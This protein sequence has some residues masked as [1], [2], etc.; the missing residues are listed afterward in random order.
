MG[1]LNSV[2]KDDA[3]ALV[4]DD[5]FGEWVWYHPHA[6]IPRRIRAVVDRFVPQKWTPGNEALAPKLIITVKNDCRE[7]IYTRDVD[8]HGADRVKLP[9][10]PGQEPKFFSLY[11]PGDGL[12]TVAMDAAMATFE[13]R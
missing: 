6:G 2:M 1:I 3:R 9:E 4:D 8:A 5:L 7:G 13:L 12:R 11:L 10:R